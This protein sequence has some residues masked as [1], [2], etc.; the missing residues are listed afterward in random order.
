MPH[1]IQASIPR[2]VNAT[3]VND[4]LTV[5]SNGFERSASVDAFNR[6]RV[7]MPE[8][9][10]DAKL[11]HGKEL[12]HFQEKTANSG[13][14]TYRSTESC[15]RLS[16][17]THSASYAARQ[18]KRYFNY[19]AGKSQLVLVTFNLHGAVA[20]CEK[21][22]GYFDDTDG[23]FLRLKST[24]LEFVRRTSTSGTVVDNPVTQANWNMDTCDGNGAS[25]FNIDTTKAQ[26]LIIDFQWLGVGAVRFG[27]VN[28]TGG[29]VYAHQM[30][31]SNTL[32]TVYMATPNLPIR[33]EVKN[34]ATC[35]GATMD[36]ICCNC[37]CESGA[38]I[39]GV[40][41]VADRGTS[42][43]STDTT[44]RPLIQVRN[45]LTNRWAREHLQPISA[46]IL[47]L[48]AS[49]NFR[50][51]LI[52]NPTVS[53]GT[54]ASWNSVDDDAHVEYDIAATGTVSGGDIM[55][56]GYAADE[57]SSVAVQIPSFRV[58]NCDFA[59]T[60]ADVLT[61]AVQCVTG[62]TKTFLGS[63]TWLETI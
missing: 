9:M 14:C 11:I 29:V 47:C 2:T 50:W 54:A 52:L 45:K 15:V 41:H 21:S 16:T 57:V 17:S 46:S 1:R 23:L 51:A 10:L 5:V 27:F 30:E 62:Q 6:L 59:G 3:I 32:A 58:I 18:T 19:R 55:A 44:L 4:S 25:G 35:D 7:S 43:L 53:G 48:S 56:S 8:S 20:G 34:V 24:G 39:S 40:Q 61:L 12:E 26:I 13:L 33:W 36:T 60:T 28:S 22:V 31:H 42:A 37:S 63:L 49:T 38:D